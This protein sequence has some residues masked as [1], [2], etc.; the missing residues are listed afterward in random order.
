MLKSETL[1]KDVDPSIRAQAVT[2]ADAVFAMKE[3]IELHIPE[4]KEMPLSLE[5]KV[6]T[7]EMVPRQNPALS[8]FR[9]LVRDYSSALKS[10]RDI[11]GD[12]VK[13]EGP[14]AV[15][16]LRGKFKVG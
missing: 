15:E 11:L 13:E 5:V 3:K 9:S 7:G 12:T 8:E 1:C 10:L 14:S 6:N 16:S 2:L 4:L